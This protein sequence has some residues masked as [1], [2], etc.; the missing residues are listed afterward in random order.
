MNHYH[1]TWMN[2]RGEYRSLIVFAWSRHHAHEL[3]KAAYP[4]AKR[5][6]SRKLRVPLS[7]NGNLSE[8]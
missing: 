1:V 7:P 2:Y 4:K 8:G 5:V 6:R 3:V